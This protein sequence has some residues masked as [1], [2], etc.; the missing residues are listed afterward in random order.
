MS[1]ARRASPRRPFT[2]PRSLP[3]SPPSSKSP[4]GG[5]SPSAR[6][7][8]PS[9]CRGKRLYSIELRRDRKHRPDLILLGYPNEA[10]EVELTSKGTSRLDGL[11][12]AW[13][14]SL[15]EKQLGCVRY[16]CSPQ[17]LPCIKRAVRRTIAEEFVGVEPLVMR[18]GS[19]GLGAASR[20][21]RGDE[22]SRQG[23]S[24]WRARRSARARAVSTWRWRGRAM[25]RKLA[26]SIPRIAI[27]EAVSR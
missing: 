19:L 13:R 24:A 21:L 26:T 16:L 11:V 5:F 18:D 10:I 23:Q 4:G 9:G 25:A 22:L 14:R 17:A 27:G 8:P 2:T 12:R 20:A 1:S 3:G 6:S 7:S 15:N